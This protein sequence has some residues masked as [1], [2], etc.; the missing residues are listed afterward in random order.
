MAR[1]DIL[2]IVLLL[3]LSYGSGR[4]ILHGISVAARRMRS[5]WRLHVVN[6]DAADAVPEL[7]RS[8]DAVADGVI[9]NGVYRPEIGTPLRDNPAPVVVIGTHLY[10]LEARRERIARVHPDEDAIARLGA[11]HLESLGRFRSFGFVRSGTRAEFFRAA[12]AERGIATRIYEAVPDGS[13]DPERLALWLRDLPKPAAVMAMHDA[14]ALVVLEA[15]ARAGL[16]VPRDV[17]LLGVDNDDLFCE[18]ADPPLSSVAVDHVRLGELAAAALRRLLANPHSKPFSLTVA[19][20]GVV[21]RQSTRPVAPA[22]ALAER[23]AAFIRHNATK[24]IGA[25]DVS[26]HLGVSR[27]LADLR[28]RQVHGESM[29]GMILRLRLDA[30]ARK[31]RETD[32]PIGQVISSCGFGDPDHARRLFRSRFGC[33]MRAWRGAFPPAT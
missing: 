26:A 29:L 32:L 2:D 13:I 10:A 6:L 11:R 5:R 15:A 21:E 24:G 4:D 9:A 25:A 18:T 1:K 33:S 23:A 14:M 7:L 12:L 19:P 8:L 28:F 30:A 31:L 20:T 22:T 16:R 17:A 3:R 27:S